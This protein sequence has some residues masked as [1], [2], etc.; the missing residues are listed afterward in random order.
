MKKL[1]YRWCELITTSASTIKHFKLILDNPRVFPGVKNSKRIFVNLE[2]GVPDDDCEFTDSHC[3][4]DSFWNFIRKH[5]AEVQEMTFGEDFFSD[6][7]D[8][9]RFAKYM[10]LLPNLRKIRCFGADMAL[11]S[12]KMIRKFD[13]DP[14]V[15]LKDHLKEAFLMES[16]SVST[17]FLNEKE[18]AFKAFISTPIKISK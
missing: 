11:Y 9:K 7:S 18:R 12:K 13:Q 10:N 4:G 2:I 3:S 8:I 14:P 15:T 5:K 1:L 6:L 17:R 16:F